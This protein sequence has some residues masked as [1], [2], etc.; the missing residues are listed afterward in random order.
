MNTMMKLR[1]RVA[2]VV[3]TAVAFVCSASAQ[4]ET[5]TQ[6]TAVARYHDEASYDMSFWSDGSGNAG[7][8][9]TELY[10][11]ADYRTARVFGIDATS[12]AFPA[13]AS[14]TVQNKGSISF[15]GAGIF[16]C[17]NLILEN[18]ANIQEYQYMSPGPQ[19]SGYP[20][21]PE[22]LYGKITV[23]STS[24]KPA[25]FWSSYSGRGMEVSSEIW[26]GANAVLDIGIDGHGR[27][28]A[29]FLFENLAHY[30]GEIRVQASSVDL[31]YPTTQIYGTNYGY[32]V[33]LENTSLPGTLRICGNN[34]TLLL[35]RSGQ[36][37]SI[38]TLVLN[39]NSVVRFGQEPA[40]DSNVEL[41][42]KMVTVENSLTIGDTVF[43]RAV[44]RKNVTATATNCFWKLL[45]G[46]VGT[47][48]DPAKFV[49]E[50]NPQYAASEQ[51]IGL[52]VTTD[53][54]NRDTLSAYLMQAT[55]SCPATAGTTNVY[56]ALV[57]GGSTALNFKFDPSN[58]ADATK[59]RSG[60]IAVDQ[61]LH[62]VGKVPVTATY[63]PVASTTGEELRTAILRGP[64]GMR[65]SADQFE[66]R[67]NAAYEGL[68]TTSTYPQRVHLEVETGAD[69]RDTLY[70]VIEPIVV[71]TTCPDTG[72]RWHDRIT[73]QSSFITPSCWSDNRYP[74][75]NA[76][77]VKT[78]GYGD[79]PIG[80]FEFPC[81]SFLYRGAWISFHSTNQEFRVER[82]FVHTG[83]FG[84]DNESNVHIVGNTLEVADTLR[85]DTWNGRI[86]QIDSELLGAGSL[87]LASASH[88]TSYHHGE[89]VFC[90]FNTNFTGKVD[91]RL[92]NCPADF[93][94]TLYGTRKKLRI[95]D[96][97]NLGG[98]RDVSTYDALSLG[99]FTEV[100][101]TNDVELAA[102]LN[103][104]ILV[105]KGDGAAES[106]KRSNVAGGARMNVEG[107]A[108][109]SVGWPLTFSVEDS[110]FPV[111]L[112]KS[113][114]GTLALGGTVSFKTGDGVTN[115]LPAGVHLPVLCV[116]NGFIRALSADCVDGL[117]VDLAQKTQTVETG[118]RLDYASGGAD[119]RAFGVRNVKTSVPFGA[120]QICLEMT[121]MPETIANGD[122]FGVLTV[123]TSVA[124]DIRSRLTVERPKVEGMSRI[125]SR[126]DDATA[127]TTTFFVKYKQAGIS[128][129]FR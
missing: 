63:T 57:L 114:T 19:S 103:R 81:R 96:G 67:P 14:L 9:T 53:A 98:R 75:A 51:A 41:A 108:T 84:H 113:G 46:P 15:T 38:G 49:F 28:V 90:S 107:D 54:D 22:R 119:M 92:M 30:E 48:I 37:V 6:N 36:D 2:M 24:T 17:A 120:G 33:R 64:A 69:G 118:I 89:Y 31:G 61:M 99:S 123:K 62:I 23:N 10:D 72:V 110:D 27:K 34:A 4:T 104:G 56:S 50:S 87:V 112:W 7:P 65:L 39:D 95:L 101:V 126:T 26:G 44:S 85:L 116:A 115:D 1:N 111:T 11:N 109:L 100:L 20:Y 29:Q 121:N 117:T 102:D 13:N 82:M 124:D 18:G 68:P 35:P 45:K 77:Y 83:A 32:A 66:F 16:T 58:D 12:R 91:A 127:G 59:V 106:T 93:V 80:F 122:T 42:T 70:A 43:V 71:M 47:R 79:T 5:W 55:V 40:S 3:A 94:P 125:L 78:I 97:R 8:T 76:H 88:G 86:I 128:V 52:I 60:C 105:V 74:H 25:Y 129:S 21:V 73:T